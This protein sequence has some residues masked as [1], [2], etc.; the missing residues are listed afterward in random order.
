MAYHR[1]NQW[2]NIFKCLLS[3][4]AKKMDNLQ[5][6]TLILFLH[7]PRCL[8]D[9]L[10]KCAGSNKLR[11]QTQGSKNIAMKFLRFFGRIILIWRSK[12]FK[13]PLGKCVTNYSF[14]N[15]LI[16]FFRFFFAKLCFSKNIFRQLTLKWL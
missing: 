2:Q 7:L 16:N 4:R 10:A 5:R 8:N 15:I 11:I 12:T 14:E 1:Q 3:Y 13:W 6:N 9:L